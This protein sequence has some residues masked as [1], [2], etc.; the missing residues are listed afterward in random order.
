VLIVLHCISVVTEMQ[1]GSLGEHACAEREAC[2]CGGLLVRAEVARSIL[3]CGLLDQSQVDA[4]EGY[5]VEI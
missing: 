2:L 1:L 5:P 3:F 4:W